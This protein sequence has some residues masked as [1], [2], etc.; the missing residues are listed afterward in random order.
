MRKSTKEL[1]QEIYTDNL[2]RRNNKINWKESLGNIVKGIYNDIEFEV[3]I[4]S[5]DET[6]S[7]YIFIQYLDK[8]LFRI[9]TTSFRKCMIGR[10]LGERTDKFKLEIEQILKDNKRDVTIVDREYRI[11]NS[12]KKQKCKWYKY[13]CNKCNNEDWVIEAQLIGRSGGCNTCGNGLKKVVLGINTIW[14][15]DKWMCNLGISEEDAKTHTYQSNDKIITICPCCGRIKDTPMMISNI[16]KRHS[17]GCSCSD[18]KSYPE[19]Y[20]FRILEQLDINFTME[21]SPKWCEFSFRG[22]I[23]NGRYDFY[24]ELNGKKY[25]I[26]TDGDWHGTFNNYS[27]ITSEESLYIDNMKDKLANDNNVNM[28]RIDCKKSTGG[29]IKNNI[30]NSELNKLFDL[31]IIDWNKAEEFALSN[32]VK[33]ACDYKNNNPNITCKEISEIMKLNRT[34]ISGYLKK[35]NSVGWCNYNPKEDNKNRTL[36]AIKS[37]SKKVEVFKDGKGVGEFNSLA[38]LRRDSKYKFGKTLNTKYVIEVCKGERESY[39]GFTFQYIT[40]SA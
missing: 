20:L 30:L 13:H 21:C 9:A 24:F 34:T 35:G 19:K 36:N 12:G 32:L 39:H 16:Y 29:Y 31:S 27:K 4:V 17:I 15:T 14:D 7:D 38:E 1:K 23:R 6:D 40:Q 25:F 33:I 37:T 26:E 3:R 10:L 11:N 8:P 2:P 18:S 22:G 5:I 28:I